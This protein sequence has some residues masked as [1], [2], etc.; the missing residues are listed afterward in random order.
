MKKKQFNGYIIQEDGKILNKDGSEKVPFG[1]YPTVKLY[2]NGKY[3]THYVHRL[4]AEAFVDGRDE[5][6]NHKD[7]NKQ[8]NHASNLEWMSYSDNN[9]H[10]RETGLNV[11]LYE[12]KLKHFDRR[13]VAA[14]YD[15]GRYRQSELCAMF[16]ISEVTLRK[17]INEFKE[18][19][20]RI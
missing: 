17:Y 20:D 11:G 16:G 14:M 10:A 9:K 19:K 12:N 8:N 6:V 1:K 2:Y 18:G 5:T 13:K 15:T 3:N 7:G 4:V